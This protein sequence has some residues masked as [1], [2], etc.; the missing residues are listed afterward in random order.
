M[1]RVCSQQCKTDWIGTE[2]RTQDVGIRRSLV[3]LESHF[4]RDV[5]EMA[6]G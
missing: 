5:G 4:R 2:K 1:E 3:A 6:V